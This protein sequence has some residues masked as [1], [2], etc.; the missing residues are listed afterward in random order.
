[1]RVIE[2]ENGVLATEK[3]GRLEEC[4]GYEEGFRHCRRGDLRQ[5]SF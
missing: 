2:G 3:A 5:Y 4:G 1:M